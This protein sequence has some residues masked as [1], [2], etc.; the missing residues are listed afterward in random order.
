MKPIEEFS[1]EEIDAINLDDYEPFCIDL[2]EYPGF[3]EE[4]KALPKSLYTP[5]DNIQ[6][7]SLELLRK[8]WVLTHEVPRRSIITKMTKDEQTKLY[9]QKKAEELESLSNKAAQT[10]RF[11]LLKFIGRLF[12]LN[13]QLNE[14]APLY[15]YKGR[16]FSIKQGKR[17]R[18]IWLKNPHL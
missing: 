11:K 12:N 3:L 18:K 13:I 14:V 15:S 8:W 9:Q 10:L 4:V 2:S 5:E 6:P 16:L 17:H 7:Y 1:Q